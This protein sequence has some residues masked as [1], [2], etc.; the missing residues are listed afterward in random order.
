M[1]ETLGGEYGEGDAD[2]AHQEIGDGQRDDEVVG[3]GV[4]PAVGREH[5]ENQP[6]ADHGENRYRDFEEEVECM[7]HGL[8]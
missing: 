2:Q 1:R 7:R 3:D 5:V 6:V 8:C 4:E